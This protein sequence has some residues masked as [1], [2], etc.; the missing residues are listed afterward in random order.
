MPNPRY[1]TRLQPPYSEMVDEY[2][3]DNDIGQSEAVRRLIKRGLQAEGYVTLPTDTH[4]GRGFVERLASAKTAL[5]GAVLFV[6]GGIALLGAGYLVSSSVYLAFGL[7]FFSGA[8]TVAG[9]ATVWL[10][11]IAQVA[12]SRPLRGL[13]PSRRAFQ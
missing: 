13:L 7:L 1:Q 6:L 2:S 8:L 3:E 10:A 12:L 4:P 9:T 11:A 5:L